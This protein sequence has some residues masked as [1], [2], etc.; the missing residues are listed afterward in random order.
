[1]ERVE[2]NDWVAYRSTNVRENVWYSTLG[3]WS[4]VLRR[5]NS[6]PN[7]SRSKMAAMTEMK[8]ASRL[9]LQV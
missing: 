4:I 9:P 8:P 3:G 1:M 7:Q 2:C 6:P 5:I